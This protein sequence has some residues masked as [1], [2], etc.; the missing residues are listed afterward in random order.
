M[1]FGVSAHTIVLNTVV[2]KM[3][4]TSAK[5]IFIFGFMGSSAIVVKGAKNHKLYNDSQLNGLQLFHQYFLDTNTAY[6]DNQI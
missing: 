3:I 6:L 4:K 2:K 5:E 1:R